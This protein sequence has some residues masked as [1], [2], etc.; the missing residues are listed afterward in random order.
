[1]KQAKWRELP[2]GN[3]GS[4][5]TASLAPMDKYPFWQDVVLANLSPTEN[6]AIEPRHK[7]SGRLNRIG[8][9]GASLYRVQTSAIR[10]V[11]DQRSLRTRPNDDFFLVSVNQ[12]RGAMTQCGRD[13]VA[14]AG[15]IIFYDSGKPFT[16]EFNGDVEMH[17]LRVPR[18]KVLAAAKGLEHVP[19]HVLNR[20]Q[21]WTTLVSGLIREIVSLHED[22]PE[23]TGRISAPFLD[24][25]MAAIN[26]SAAGNA[27][28]P[29]HNDIV[30]RAKEH[31]LRN[32]DNPELTL[33]DVCATL[34]VSSRTLCR[35][36]ATDGQSAIGWLW[37][38][39]TEHARRIIE[40]KKVDTVSQAAMQSGFS[41]FS[42]FARTFKAKYGI[43][44]KVLLRQ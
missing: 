9:T 38:Q 19:T 23:D 7:F 43:L 2:S 35:I 42:H 5:D 18:R 32:I 39:R 28:K 14:G 29:A 26:C 20:D 1:M 25:V 22:P 37:E 11:R 8:L 4:Y 30:A 21:P 33:N 15:D 24:M 34:G 17:I 40:E 27:A 6:V 10:Y 12:G 31:M 3:Q 36:F 13:V 44:P 41:N 16:W